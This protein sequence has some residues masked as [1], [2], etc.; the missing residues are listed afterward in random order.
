MSIVVTSLY[1]IDRKLHKIALNADPIFETPMNLARDIYGQKLVEFSYKRKGQTMYASANSISGYVN[2]TVA[3]GMLDEDLRPTLPKSD[4]RSLGNFQWWLKD[5][6]MDHLSNNNASPDE[7]RSGIGKLFSTTPY[8][9][10]TIDNVYNILQTSM[11]KFQF[12]LS[13]KIVSALSP[14][15]LTLSS[16]KL[17]IHPDILEIPS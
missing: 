7:I 13:I 11:S 5:K 4:F 17:V 14:K 9:L 16:R 15:V 10:P 3:I 8:P 2:Y 6:V 1:G 12:K